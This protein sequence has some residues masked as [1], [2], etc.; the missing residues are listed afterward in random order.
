MSFDQNTILDGTKKGSIARFVNHSCDPNC[1]MVKWVVNGKPRMALFVGERDI[2]T[3]EELTYDYNFD[4]FSAKNVQECRCGSTNCRGILGPR[5]KDQKPLKPA[6][7]VSGIKNVIGKGKRKLQEMMGVDGDE[8][9][10]KKRK[11]AEPKG[12]KRSMS[13]KTL[14]AV[15][16]I[17]RSVSKSL[18]V[19][20][21]I[22]LTHKPRVVKKTYKRS[23]GIEKRKVSGLSTTSSLT[24]VATS[25]SKKA[26]SV[27][28]VKIKA[29]PKKLQRKGGY[30]KKGGWGGVRIK[31]VKKA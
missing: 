8:K 4:P 5:P 13:T 17:K 15:A 19:V 1:R 7:I 14:D 30:V 22:K 12:V 11:I 3:G 9:A 23:V 31:G 20:A 26:G 24:M 16:G 2:M 28:S 10:I 6:A 18:G 29:A 25:E 27:K 21:G